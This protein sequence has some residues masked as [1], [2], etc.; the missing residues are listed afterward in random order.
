MAKKKLDI[1]VNSIENFFKDIL[2][3]R[4]FT[5]KDAIRCSYEPGES[6]LVVVTGENATG[7]SFLRRV[8]H[9]ALQQNEIELIALSME[10]RTR[11]G[12]IRKAFIY[13]DEGNSSTGQISGRTVT[14]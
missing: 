12:D 9:S 2:D 11:V 4:F 3:L 5:M 10:L 14:T 6:K 1:R 13:G 7:K 8:I